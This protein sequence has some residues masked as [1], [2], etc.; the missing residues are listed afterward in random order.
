M[1][2]H[3][4]TFT[5]GSPFRS[6]WWEV[7]VWCRE[8]LANTLFGYLVLYQQLQ[9]NRRTVQS[10]LYLLWLQRHD[11]HVAV[12]NSRTFKV[13]G[14]L[15]NYGCSTLL[16][17]RTPHIPSYLTTSLTNKKLAFKSGPIGSTNLNKLPTHSMS[18]WCQLWV[19]L[20]HSST[21]TSVRYCEHKPKN[22][23]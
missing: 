16:L 7:K 11:L 18:T 19:V 12:T 21:C 2:S 8:G 22:K 20:H 17:G 4:C 6:Q 13:N 14:E 3:T 9:G 23:D 5:R 1:T 15:Q 10:V